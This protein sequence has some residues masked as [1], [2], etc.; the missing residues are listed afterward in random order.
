MTGFDWPGL[1]RL[2][3]HG[4]GLKP[5]EFWSLTPVELQ[6]LFGGTDGPKPLARARFE[7]LLEAF[8]DRKGKTD[9]G[10]N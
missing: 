8:P 3:F 6:V 1:M 10:G 2:G 9:H 5:H 4:L 7:E